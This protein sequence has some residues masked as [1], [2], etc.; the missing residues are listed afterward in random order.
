MTQ[1]Q[2][3]PRHGQARLAAIFLNS[4]VIYALTKAK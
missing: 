2:K 1:A 3:S 4:H